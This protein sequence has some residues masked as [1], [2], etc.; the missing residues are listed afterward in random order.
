MIFMER[1]DLRNAEKM[2]HTALEID[3]KLGRPESTANQYGN[4]GK[5]FHTRGDLNEAEKMHR[6][7]LKIDVKLARLEGMAADYGNLG[8]VFQA[9][10]EPDEARK[11]W[12]KARDLY[13]EIGIPHMVERVQ[14][15]LDDLPDAGEDRS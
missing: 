14:G 13:A 11:L 1:G 2:F 12:T 7:S 4:L 8:L 15:G 3:E 5:I 9:R 6:K 10:G